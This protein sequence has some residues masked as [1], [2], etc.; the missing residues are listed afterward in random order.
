MVFGFFQQSILLWEK[1]QKEGKNKFLHLYFNPLFQCLA[2]D[3]FLCDYKGRITFT[4]CCKINITT[5]VKDRLVCNN[6]F[7]CFKLISRSILDACANASGRYLVPAKWD[8]FLPFRTLLKCYIKYRCDVIISID[9]SASNDLVKVK[10]AFSRT[11]GRFRLLEPP[12][13]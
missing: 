10:V 2:L 4:L 7:R 8:T 5:F 1:E 12:L 9:S 6:N 13:D 11:I 3:Q